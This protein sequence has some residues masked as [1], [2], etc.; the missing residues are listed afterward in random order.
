MCGDSGIVL[1]MSV[2]FANASSNLW[3]DCISDPMAMTDREYFGWKAIAVPKHS[4]AIACRPPCKSNSP[5]DVDN[6]ACSGYFS[7]PFLYTSMAS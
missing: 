2:Y 6:S 4:R 3:C 1:E 5:K 7:T